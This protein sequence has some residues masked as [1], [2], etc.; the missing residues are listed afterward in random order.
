[1]KIKI[2]KKKPHKNIKIQTKIIDKKK[3]QIH[4]TKRKMFVCVWVCT[5]WLW[6]SI[7]HK[8]LQI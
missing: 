8:G 1:M 6:K 4:T 2:L 7:A 3:T 5:L